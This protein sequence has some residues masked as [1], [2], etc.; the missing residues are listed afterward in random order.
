MG[1]TAYPTEADLQAFLGVTSDVADEVAS[2]I[3]EWETKTSWIPFLAESSDSTEYFDGPNSPVLPVGYASITSVSIGITSTDNTG[4]ALV[5]N[6]GYWLEFNLRKAITGIRFGWHSIRGW[7][8]IKIIGK[9]GYS[10]SIPDEVWLAILHRAAVKALPKIN[11]MGSV[12]KIKQG[13]VEYD[14]DKT[15][16]SEWAQEFKQLV[17]DFKRLMA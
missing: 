4:T 3:S 12:I 15:R 7:K 9:K 17:Y 1:K 6:E 5:L 13:P 8:T 16:E 10:S 11:Q 2:A 14:L